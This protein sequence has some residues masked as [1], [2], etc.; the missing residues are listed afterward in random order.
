MIFDPSIE[1]FYNTTYT[2]TINTTATDLLK[3]PL[4]T[5]YIWNFTTEKE[6]VIE[7]DTDG[8]GIPNDID[9]DDDNDG[10]TDKEELEAGTDPLNQDDH[11]RK[12]DS[13]SKSEP[14]DFILELIIIIIP[15]AILVIII[16][17]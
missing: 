9:D 3:N 12:K 13:W 8:D 4:E 7:V 5:I 2:V 10:F 17:G 16:L 14:G 6:S 15:L 11:Q 1:L